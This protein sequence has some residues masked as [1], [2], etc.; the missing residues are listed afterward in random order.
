MKTLWKIKEKREDIFIKFGVLFIGIFEIFWKN[1]IAIFLRQLCYDLKIVKI[2]SL[3]LCEN[4][5]I[6]NFGRKVIKMVF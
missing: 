4:F 6:R 5:Y 3:K 2:F 1:C